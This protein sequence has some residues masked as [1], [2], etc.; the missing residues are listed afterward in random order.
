MCKY[1][2]TYFRVK[3]INNIELP[4]IYKSYNAAINVN[5][6]LNISL[7]IRSS[8]KLTVESMR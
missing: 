1:I 2:L 4:L 6:S 7:I 8:L 5:S 3:K